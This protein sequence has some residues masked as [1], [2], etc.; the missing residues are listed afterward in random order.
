MEEK[1]WRFRKLLKKRKKE[2]R[3]MCNLNF[4]TDDYV[5]EE[6]NIED[7]RFSIQKFGVLHVQ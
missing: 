7:I 2:R 3:I 5:C 6:N 1:I 4:L